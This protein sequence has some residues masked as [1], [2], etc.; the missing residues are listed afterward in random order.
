MTI[1]TGIA[2]VYYRRPANLIDEGEL[3]PQIFPLFEDGRVSWFDRLLGGGIEVPNEAVAGSKPR[4]LIMLL[5][6]APGTGKTTFALELA[7]RVALSEDPGALA[8]YLSLEEPAQNLV[9]KCRLNDWCPPS[10]NVKEYDDFVNPTFG[11]QFSKGVVIAGREMLDHQKVERTDGHGKSIDVRGALNS[12]TE[13]LRSIKTNSDRSDNASKIDLL[14]VD[15]L[16]LLSPI[17]P[18]EP[19]AKAVELLRGDLSASD[20]PSRISNQNYSLDNLSGDRDIG[21]VRQIQDAAEGDHRPRIIVM[22][23]DT[24]SSDPVSKYCESVADIVFTFGWDD[25]DGYLL[26]SFTIK[27][28]R[29]QPHALGKQRLKIIPGRS[30]SGEKSTLPHTHEHPYVEQGGVFIFPSIHWHLKQLS[31]ERA[32]R[33]SKVEARYVPLE[34]DLENLG[35][36]LSDIDG[37]KGLP[38]AGCTAIVGPRGGMKSQLAYYF[39]LQQA[40]ECKK[41]VLLISLRDDVPRAVETLDRIAKQQKMNDRENLVRKLIKEDRLEILENE[42]GM[43]SPEEFFHKVYVAVRRKRRVDEQASARVVVVNGL[44]QLEARFPL[45]AR[46]AMFVPGLIQFLKASETCTLIVS[47][48]G[49]YTSREGA[50]LYGLLPMAELILRVTQIEFNELDKADAK[51][52]RA[53]N[54]T[55]RDINAILSNQI[56]AV[57]TVRVPGGQIG[58]RVGFI[59]RTPDERM[60]YV[61]RPRESSV[62]VNR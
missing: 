27:K 6:G 11:M 38:D 44:D 34:G 43:I 3:A 35:K 45:I 59:N 22:I 8:L 20:T 24:T 15:S 14:I 13:K 4:S 51:W 36:Q 33:R 18:D 47:A 56:A 46:E 53:L 50:A 23:L 1:K 7:T 21:P 39:L 5:S 28:M 40:C 37:N 32:L 29:N 31:R 30:L 54:H 9:R 57:E 61:Y 60:E 62:S 52:G 16:N 49:D 19:R 17:E 42:V 12:I 10:G 41:D 58:G 2:P 25:A 55:F 48:T 26:R